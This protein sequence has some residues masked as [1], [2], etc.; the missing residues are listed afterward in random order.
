MYAHFPVFKNSCTGSG[1][2]LVSMFSTSE[3]MEHQRLGVRTKSCQVKDFIFM[4]GKKSATG[5][6]G[7][8]DNTPLFLYK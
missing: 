3:S 5:S 4:K 6:G 8:D 7:I 2:N 1:S